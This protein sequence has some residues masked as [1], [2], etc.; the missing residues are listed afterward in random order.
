MK[1]KAQQGADY[2]LRKEE[3][4]SEGGLRCTKLTWKALSEPG[5]LVLDDI[6]GWRTIWTSAAH[7][8][9]HEQVFSS[10]DGA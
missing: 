2:I 4:S 3:M 6:A 5:S 8:E 1:E 7:C 10:L 9:R